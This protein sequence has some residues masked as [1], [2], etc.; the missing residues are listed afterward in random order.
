MRALG[1]RANGVATG[2]EGDSPG[3]AGGWE[4]KAWAALATSSPGPPESSADASAW[5]SLSPRPQVA[6]GPFNLSPKEKEN[7]PLPFQGCCCIL[8]L[9]LTVKQSNTI[10]QKHTPISGSRMWVSVCGWQTSKTAKSGLSFTPQKIGGKECV[11]VCVCA[12]D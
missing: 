3:R 4:A 8:P 12:Y 11:C 9:C 2:S 7:L 5:L 6:F 10:T 1:T